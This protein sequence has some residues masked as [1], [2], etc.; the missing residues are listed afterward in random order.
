MADEVFMAWHLAC[1]VESVAKAGT[2]VYALPMYVNAWLVCNPGDLPG[3]YP[4]GGP[5]SR[6]MDIWKA[7]APSCFTLAPD[8]YLKTFREVCYDY[9]RDDNPLLIP[10]AAQG[11]S[12]AAN[13]LFAFGRHQAIAFSPFGIEGFGRALLSKNPEGASAFPEGYVAGS[14]APDVSSGA[15]HYAETC[16][17]LRSIPPALES[18]LDSGLSDGVVQ[19]RDTTDR[20]TVVG[21]CFK[22]VFHKKLAETRIPAGAMIIAAEEP[23]I[24]YLL[25]FGLRIEP[26]DADPATCTEILRHEEGAFDAQG[27]WRRCRVL[28]GDELGLSL[29]THPSIRRFTLFRRAALSDRPGASHPFRAPEH[30]KK[31]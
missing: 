8:I 27:V 4:S 22:V 15:R 31:K 1:F 24:F 21:Q 26:I 11:P 20:M 6:V 5:V 7:G 3:Q 18:R 9:V 12:A 30:S 10:E 28:N 17:L 25:G 13:A 29:G 23:D 2:A 14:A 19:D 16:S